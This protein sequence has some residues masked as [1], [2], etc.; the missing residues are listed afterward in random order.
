MQDLVK[1]TLLNPVLSLPLFLLLRYTTEG[2]SI[3]IRHATVLKVL[4]YLVY[5]GVAK[6]INGILNNK[7]LNNGTILTWD[8]SKE[9]VLITG[10]SD[11]IGKDIVLGLANARKNVKIIIL[12][13][14]PPTYD[15]RTNSPSSSS[16][17]SLHS[18][19]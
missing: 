8:W 16:L 13:I 14:Q 17:S 1:K 3:A 15:L 18:T 11:G 6:R 2:Q 5:I 9:I 12:D 7:V 4:K 10:G 19:N